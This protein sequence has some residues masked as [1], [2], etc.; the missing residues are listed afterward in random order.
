MHHLSHELCDGRWLAL[1]GGGYDLYDA[2]PRAWTIV[3]AE[4]AAAKLEPEIPA[5]WQEFDRIKGA[6]AP[7][8]NLMDE[9]TSSTPGEMAE[10]AE[11]VRRVQAAIPLLN[12]AT[13]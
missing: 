6:P 8:Q 3:F 12:S 5:S 1:G 13:T 7:P 2:V 4:M 9:P 11:T 10:V